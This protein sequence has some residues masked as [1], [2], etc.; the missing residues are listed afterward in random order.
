MKKQLLLATNNSGKI[1]E[2]KAILAFLP[3][4]ILKT[5]AELGIHLNVVES[6]STYQENAILK[7]KSFCSVSGIISI[8]DDSGLEVDALDGAPGLFS[9]RYSPKNGANDKD[10]RDFLLGRL[11][12]AKR[13]WK[14]QFKATIAIA[15][16]DEGMITGEGVCNGEIIPNETGSGGFGYDPIFFMEE[17][18]RTMAELDPE[19]KN[20]ISHRARAIMSVKQ[21]LKELFRHE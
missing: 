9:A 19:T 4:N 8:A 18:G 20:Q 11:K 13:P 15:I 16:P 7:A 6:G 10:R 1:E 17:Y 14:A 21:E 3:E 2:L 12:G 5:P